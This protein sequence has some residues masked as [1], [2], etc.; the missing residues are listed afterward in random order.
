[1]S[2]KSKFLHTVHIGDLVGT[3]WLTP[4]IS[5]DPSRVLGKGLCLGASEQ[6]PLASREI[7]TNP[8]CRFLDTV[9]LFTSICLEREAMASEFM[10][11]ELSLSGFWRRPTKALESL[12]QLNFLQI[13]L[14][15]L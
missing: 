4:A 2:A 5:L 6:R 9:G 11:E 15:Q 10:L 12:T 3:V 8:A 13:S 7:V 14:R 1:M